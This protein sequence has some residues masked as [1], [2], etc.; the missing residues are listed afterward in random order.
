MVKY[1][2]IIPVY[3]S[4]KTIE[5]C[6]KSLLDQGRED[7]QIITVDDGSKDRSGE[8]IREMAKDHP[9]IEYIYQEN[10]GVSCARNHGLDHAKGIYV[11]FVD[12]DDFVEP[13]Y[14]EAMD[15]AGD[16]D[17]L[18]FAHRA[19]GKSPDVTELFKVLD[20]LDNPFDRLKLLLSS[21]RIMSPCDK[22]FR[23]EI[24][25]EKKIRF[26]QG[27]H[28]GEDFNFCMAYAMHSRRIETIRDKIIVF[29]VSNENSLSRK[30]RPH[31]DDQMVWE[32]TSAARTIQGGGVYEAQSGILLRELDYLFIKHLFSSIMEE[33]RGGKLRFFRDHRRLTEIC[34]KFRP[35]IGEGYCGMVH[36]GLRMALACRAHVLFYAV[37]YLKLKLMR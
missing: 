2:V 4:E 18:T 25:E 29:D 26:I 31:L 10:A 13:D 23:R 24:I 8:I 16:C 28:I 33:L 36:R 17:L 22:R 15:R 30:Y 5:R 32:F 20:T 9:A 12:S 7:L 1:S 11:S 14:F 37:C 21:R 6:L 27:M 34:G 19:I 3:N 35:R